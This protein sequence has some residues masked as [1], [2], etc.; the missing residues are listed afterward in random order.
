M[1]DIDLLFLEHYIFID[2]LSLKPFCGIFQWKIRSQ[3]GYNLGK[4]LL[5]LITINDCVEDK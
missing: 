3:F 2:R 1:T 5:K 4:I